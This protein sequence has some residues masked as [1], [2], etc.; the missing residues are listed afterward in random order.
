MVNIMNATT[1]ARRGNATT[2][3]MPRQFISTSACVSVLLG[4]LF[5]SISVHAG[6]R[7]Q[8]SFDC[9]RAS[10]V[11]EKTVCADPELSRLDFQL[12][13]AWKRIVDAFIDSAQITQMNS[14]QRL[15]IASR[16][17]CDD[18]ATCIG[19]LYRDRL[20]TLS[21]TD[22]A[23]RFSGVYEV[24]DIGFVALYPI[25]DHYLVH[26]QTAD[27]SDGK[28]ECDLAGEAQSSGDD[29]KIRVE[30][31]VFQARLRDPDTLVVGDI[32]GVSAAGNQY[33]GLNGTFAFS[34]VRARLIP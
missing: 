15:W 21:G 24:K 18:D 8:P 20:A 25:G 1:L 31:T 10:S 13:H 30:K 14:D 17:K 29:L 11:S 9:R 22:P 3:E 27:P 16:A 19:K 6:Q 4:S 28:W 33:C 2:G 32:E 12:G 7:Q 5:L 34:F 26:I 23:H